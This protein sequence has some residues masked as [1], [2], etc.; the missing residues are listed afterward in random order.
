MVDRRDDR[1]STFHDPH[2]PAMLDLTDTRAFMRDRR[3][4]AWLVYDF[5]GINP[6][7]GQLLGGQPRFT[8]RR[9]LLVVPAADGD[10]YLVAH[11]IDAPLLADVGLPVRV[12]TTW[13]QWQ[14]QVRAAVAGARA[15][16]MDYSPLGALPAVSI[17]D[18]G[19]VEF[20]RSLGVDVASSADLIQTCVARWSDAALEAHR[21]ASRLVAETKDA[22]FALIHDRL[23]NG[24][25]VTERDVQRFILDRFADLGLDPQDPPIVAADAHGADPHFEVPAD[26]SATIAR[27]SWVLLDLW[28]RFP[29]QQNVFSDITWVAFAGDRVPDE[30]ARVFD[31]VRAARDT[32]LRRVTEAFAGGTPVRGF[33][34]DRAARAEV[35]AAG[36]GHAVRHRTGHSLSPGPKIHGYGAN[37]DD[38][39][40]HDTRLI[41]PRTG[42]TIEPALYLDG[43]FGC[44][45]EINVYVDPASG[46]TVTSPIQTEVVLV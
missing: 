3:L 45:L 16:A 40:T 5:R 14:E 9:L 39:E 31:V 24:T 20:V 32:A 19:V 13:P 43:R 25:P 34:L 11:N 12:Y 27:G 15:V 30:H 42:F 26:G 6:V 2:S 28:A 21:E 8:T 44:R 41:L 35:E 33:E 38:L 29:G 23:A 4:D 1:Q 7:L 37:L 17:V 10:A 22:A 18:A 46:P 36:L